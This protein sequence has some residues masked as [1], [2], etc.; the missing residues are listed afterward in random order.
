ME[1]KFTKGELIIENEHAIYDRWSNTWFCILI[2]DK[3]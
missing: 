3:G 2:N 1:T